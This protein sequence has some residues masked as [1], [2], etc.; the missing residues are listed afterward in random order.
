MG[1]TMA[2][3]LT[4]GTRTRF[5]VI[6]VT[7]AIGLLL[8]IGA[9]AGGPISTLPR[10]VVTGFF[11]FGLV[12]LLYLVIEELLVE[13]HEVPETPIVT[14]MFFVGFLSLILLEDIL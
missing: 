13:A 2:I 1:V 5:Q 7:L 4:E 3:R 10:A 11:A 14:A 6:L 12:A 8:P 9:L